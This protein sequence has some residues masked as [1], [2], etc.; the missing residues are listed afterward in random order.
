MPD[1][2]ELKASLKDRRDLQT[3][4]NEG[5]RDQ[6][7]LTNQYAT[8]LQT[9]L[10]STKDITDDMRDRA[11]VLNTLLKNNEKSLGL[12]TRNQVDFK[13]VLMLK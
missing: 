3:Q 13:K 2:K 5:L 8:L 9:Q 1:D 6:N 4:I 12:D 11:S 7:N 10:D